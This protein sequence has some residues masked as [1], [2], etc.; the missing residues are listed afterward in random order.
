MRKKNM[1]LALLAVSLVLT[2]SVGSAWAYFTPYVEAQ[3]GH[4]IS[5]GDETEVY[6][7]FSAWMKRLVVGIDE[8]SEPVYVRARAFSG[9]KYPLSYGVE[10]NNEFVP[11]PNEDCKWVPNEDGYYYYQD[12]L[13]YDAEDE[14]TRKTQEL[15][16]KINDVPQDVTEKKF[17]VVVIYETAPV[18]YKEDGTA[19]KCDETDENGQKII[20]DNKV[21]TGK[22][23][24]E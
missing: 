18:Q 13:Y 4:T 21:E 11:L 3:G 8:D 19:Y 16:I 17:D 5:L 15:Q 1:I 12:Y 14:K 2:G 20:W 9:E 24:T 23:G 7:D 6:E 10:K 22:G